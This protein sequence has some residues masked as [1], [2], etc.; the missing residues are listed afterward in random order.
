LLYADDTII[1]AE[2]PESL[3]N[4][5][6]SFENYCTRWKLKVNLN[7]TKVVIFC[8]RKSR[9]IQSFKLFG[10]A[11]DIVDSYSYLGVTFNYTGTFL[12]D[13]KL[14]SEQAQ[15]ALFSL[16]RKLR[17]ISVP[18]DLQLKLFDTLILPILTYGCEVWGYENVQVLEKIHLQFV[19]IFLK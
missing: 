17:N 16:Y 12:K 4:A 5:L 6:N 7:K 19:E 11:L 15:K 9:H 2:T 1:L 3:Q 10:H 8:K 14:K 18:V 13:K